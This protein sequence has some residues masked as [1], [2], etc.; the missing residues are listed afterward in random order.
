MAACA[1]IQALAL[2]LPVTMNPAR[3][4]ALMLE[5]AADAPRDALIV[6]P[7]GV[8]SGYE[9]K[10]DLVDRIDRAA[11]EEAIARVAAFVEE[12][13][14]H[15]VAGACVF[16]D[17]YWR[18]RSLYFG[19][20]GARGIYNKINLAMSERE[21]FTPG[22]VL[23]VIPASIA[24]LGAQMCRE[25]RYP[26]QWRVLAAQGAQVFAYPNNAVGSTIGHELWR[27]HLISRAAE[28]QRFIV[29]ANNAAPDQTCPTM[30]V[31]PSGEVLA[32]APIGAI[33]AIRAELDLSQ[34]TD[35]VLS[36]AR[37]DVV[38]VALKKP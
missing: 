19:P 38:D 3:N 14:V 16:E 25:I 21:R 1:P 9:P 37:T 12:R 30:I 6:A 2:Q 24:P 5:L 10:A 32:Q 17:G 27:A 31:A 33:V 23:P 13:S 8:L 34:V 26:E 36:Q 18:N 7:E 20:G 28:T 15:L 29:G 22:D 35:W 4:V 11:T